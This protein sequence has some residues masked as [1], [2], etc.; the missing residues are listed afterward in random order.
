MAEGPASLGPIRQADLQTQADA[1]YG[2]VGASCKRPSP[3]VMPGPQLSPSPVVGLNRAVAL[4]MAFGPE[5]G[6]ELVDALSS[7]SALEDYHLLPSVRGDQLERVGRKD[8]ARAE[9]ERAAGLTR[10]MRERELL[11]ERARACATK[12]QTND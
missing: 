7:E 10:N 8:E 12:S 4:A 5:T 2:A 3:P 6:L 9:F 11:T 1:T